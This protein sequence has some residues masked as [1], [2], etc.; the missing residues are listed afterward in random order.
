M[1]K[2]K[3][4]MS[5]KTIKTLTTSTAIALASVGGTAFAQEAQ[6]TPVPSNTAVNEPALVAKPQV[7]PLEKSD[8]EAPSTVKPALDAQ[9]AV[10]KDAETKVATAK[11]DVKAKE[12]TVAS[13]EKEVATATQ[14]V[15]DAEA[16]TAQATPEKVEQVKDAQAK[17]LE[18]QTAN[19]KATEATNEQIK[20]ETKALAEEQ[21]DVATAQANLDQA[22]KDVQTAEQAVTSAQSAL[23]GTGLASAQNDLKDAQK[24]VKEAEDTVADAQTAFKNAT[25]ADADRDQAIKSAETDVNTKND[26]VKLAKDKLASA[27]E[28]ATNVESKLQSAQA[29]LKY[30]QDKLTNTSASKDIVKIGNP[31]F[32]ISDSLRDKIGA[33]SNDITYKDAYELWRAND[34]ETTRRVM[35]GMAV[36]MSASSTITIDEK[37]KNRPVD[38]DNLTDDQLVEISEFYAKLVTQLKHNFGQNS[39][40]KVQITRKTLDYSKS[41]AKKYEERGLSPYTAGHI[42]GGLENL[43]TMGDKSVVKTMYDLKYAAQRAFQLTSYEDEVENWGHLKNNLSNENSKTVA[44]TVANINGE[45]WMITTFGSLND[46]EGDKVITKETDTASLEKAVATAEANLAQAKTASENAKNALTKASNDYASAL[47][48]KTEAEKV[49]ADAMATPLQAQVAENNLRLAEIALENAKTREAKANDAVANFSASLADK[50]VALE[51]AQKALEEVKAVQTTASQALENATAKLKAQEDKVN[52]LN[53]QSAKLLEEKDALVK[54]ATEL[55]EQ[56]QAY[57][58]APAKLATAKDQQAQ[59]EAKL[60]QVKDELTTAQ[61]TL[62]NLLS[63]YRTEHAKLVDLQTE[64]EALVDLAEKAQDNVV[65]KLPDGTVIAVPKV[66]PTAEALPEVNIAELQQALSTGKEVTLDAQGNVV[67]KEPVSIENNKPVNVA[68]T[69]TA[70]A[71]KQVVKQAEAKK[72]ELPNTGESTSTLGVF[73]LIGVLTGFSLAS[74]KNKEN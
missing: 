4:I 29:E 47:S 39:S 65:A 12:S 70:N 35:R 58:D 18:A 27:T 8:V 49:L 13:T 26:A 24:A 68:S 72:A 73:G 40:K 63:A 61:S 25:K 56:L 22:N 60:A 55:A 2:E 5:N 37:D 59:A 45:Y 20:A 33:K 69:Y 10:V 62:E 44:L 7:K 3:T 23:D 30:A 38:L 53:K 64:Y 28:H 50:K 67:V 46:F 31:T 51:N 36:K 16:T 54:E 34:N 41:V 48:L 6:A 19:Q 1:T 42:P 52:T 66:A 15:K 57:L 71:Q 14:A 32:H 9:K 21:S 74:R 17:N 43:T 11:A